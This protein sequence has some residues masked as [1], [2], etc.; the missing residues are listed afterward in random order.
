MKKII[1]LFTGTLF[2]VLTMFMG[3]SIAQLTQVRITSAPARTSQAVATKVDA[4]SM[5][6]LPGS[7]IINRIKLTNGQTIQ[8]RFI[9]SSTSLSKT[10]I[11]KNISIQN[12]NSRGMMVVHPK[13]NVAADRIQPFVNTTQIVHSQ[14]S[15]GS[16]GSAGSAGPVTFQNSDGSLCTSGVVTLDINS[17]DQLPIGARE[18]IE[19]FMPGT[20]FDLTQESA[21][22]HS[23]L[24]SRKPITLYCDVTGESVVV[25]NPSESNLNT[26][27][28]GMLKKL[29]V[30]S[31]SISSIKS[32]EINSEEEFA[33]KISGG[34]KCAYGS[35]SD[36]FDFKNNKTAYRFLFDFS[37]ESAVIKC[38]NNNDDFFT[39]INLQNN[40]DYGFVKAATYGRRIL[41]C[42]ETKKFSS[43][44]EQKLDI[45]FNA[46]FAS[47][48]AGLDRAQ[49]SMFSDCRVTVLAIGGNS[50]DAAGTA[51]NATDADALKQKLQ[52]YL[53]HYDNTMLLP[54][55]VTISDLKG[56][57][58]KTE[59]AGTVPYLKCFDPTEH[60]KVTV[61]KVEVVSGI[62]NPYRMW[63]SF[64]INAYSEKNVENVTNTH[65][66]NDIHGRS[67]QL[68]LTTSAN[69]IAVDKAGSAYQF[70]SDLNRE[71]VMDTRNADAS[72][73]FTTALDDN[74]DIKDSEQKG[75]YT[76]YIKDI[77]DA[78]AASS[79]G[80]Y[81]EITYDVTGG[82]FSIKIT[83]AISK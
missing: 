45:T 55:K 46:V 79:T 58:K 82:G 70:N 36:L 76:L 78:L 18:F 15:A 51:I 42:V 35:V 27:I 30:T 44:D 3:G 49:K 38:D 66:I 22:M 32:E 23:I 14:T 56:V 24:N 52:D 29:P 9:S 19:R 60:F 28:A 63:G 47:G 72:I 7:A 17:T 71:F 21:L 26:T 13:L 65:T 75:K 37:E 73:V 67:P 16:G 4:Q 54:I 81:S 2:I 64:W 48:S 50:N 57:P 43:A 5:K 25:D 11:A 77:Q 68:N 41:V 53:G 10:V 40:P 83:F 62:R 1:K 31:N 69:Y 20:V 61:K 8:T 33:L 34:G 39:D 74:G 6:L 12:P 59:Q 80:N